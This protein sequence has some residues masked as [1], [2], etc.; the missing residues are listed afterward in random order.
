MQKRHD[1]K[2]STMELH[3]FGTNFSIGLVTLVAIIATTYTKLV[4]YHLFN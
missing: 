3:L 4:L 2:V 1:S